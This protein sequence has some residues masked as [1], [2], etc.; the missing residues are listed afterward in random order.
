MRSRRDLDTDGRSRA[1][2]P[3]SAYSDVADTVIS[4]EGFGRHRLKQKG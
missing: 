3:R 2:A 4:R 1:A